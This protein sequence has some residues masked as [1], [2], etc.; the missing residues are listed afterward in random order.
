MTAQSATQS[1]LSN[2]APSAD[3]ELPAPSASGAALRRNRR[4]GVAL[5]VTFDNFPP[6]AAQRT[7]NISKSGVFV[8]T[9]LSLPLHTRLAIQIR[10]PS[11]GQLTTT[12]EVMHVVTSEQADGKAYPAGIGLRFFHSNPDFRRQLSSYIT[13]LQSG[14]PR[15]L[16]VDDDEDFRAALA[17]GLGVLGM[18]VDFAESGEDALQKLLEHLF[19]ID[20]VLLDIRMPG[21]D[22]RGFLHRVRQLGG[23]MDLPIVVLS[24]APRAELQSLKGPHA[25]NDVLSKND[26]LEEIAARVKDVLGR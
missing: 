23:E 22:G 12:A 19:Q 3:V 18:T 8:K 15:V 9:D 10:L 11:G 20:L 16:I 5:D 24:A 1:Q 14:Y 17:D 26:P 2:E 6:R 21:L 13:D 7:T 4:F 25:A